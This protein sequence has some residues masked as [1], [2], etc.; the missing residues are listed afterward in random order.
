MASDVFADELY[1]ELKYFSI[2]KVTL[3]LLIC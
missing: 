2:A 3:R 1:G